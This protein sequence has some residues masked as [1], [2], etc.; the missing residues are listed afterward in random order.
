MKIFTSTLLAFLIFSISLI[1]QNAEMDNATKELYNKGNKSMKAGDFQG[2]L[3]SYDEALKS[4]QD[5]RIYY[6]RGITLKKMRKYEGAIV[7]FQNAT[8]SNPESDISHNGLGSTYYITGQY[9]LAIEAFKKFGDLTKKESLKNRAN[10]NIAR[11]FAKLAE[12]AK[13]EAS[14]EKA[15]GYAQEAVSYHNYD[16]AYLILAE[17]YIQ[18]SKYTEALEAADKALNYR[19]KITKGGPYYFKGL[20]FLKLGE[21]EKAR[22]A[23]IEGKKDKTYAKNCEYEL[24]NSNL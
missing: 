23:F 24:K 14:Y 13:A 12:T 9:N 11:S 21:M 5:Y 18:I 15:I 19:K 6:Q 22:E 17:A 7:A 2:A 3:T 4:S 10:E 8:K 16:S 1:A 20:A